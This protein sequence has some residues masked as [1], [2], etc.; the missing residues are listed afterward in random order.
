MSWA[1][2][3]AQIW[4]T[5][6]SS[7]LS[8]RM[9]VLHVPLQSILILHSFFSVSSPPLSP[10][11]LI[12]TFFSGVHGRVDDSRAQLLRRCSAASGGGIYFHLHGIVHLRDLHQICGK[13]IEGMPP[14]SVFLFSFLLP[15][16]RFFFLLAILHGP[17]DAPSSAFTYGCACLFD[18]PFLH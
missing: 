1:Y 7:F 4:T 9:F 6:V 5:N 17:F 10:N 2:V 18:L 13:K 15:C 8:L 11:H 16:F 14:S 3:L 12:M